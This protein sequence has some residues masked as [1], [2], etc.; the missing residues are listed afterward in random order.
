MDVA[1]LIHV[2]LS[3]DLQSPLSSTPFSPFLSLDGHSNG[4]PN[5][6]LDEYSDSDMDYFN[7][8]FNGNTIKAL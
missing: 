7:N 5:R 4:H 1:G 3:N 6:H 8:E 2:P